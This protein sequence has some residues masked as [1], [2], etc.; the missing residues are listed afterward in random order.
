M[1]VVVMGRC[2]EYEQ[3]QQYAARLFRR[4]AEPSKFIATL[5][6]PGR[7]KTQPGFFVF[8]E[9]SPGTSETWFPPFHNRLFLPRWDLSED[10]RA[11]CRGCLTA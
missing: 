5:G 6:K 2:D 3:F 10:D 11:D 7:I 9:S 1:T 8:T 4:S